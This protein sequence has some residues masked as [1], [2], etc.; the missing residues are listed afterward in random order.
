MH[1]IFFY[2]NKKTRH[3]RGTGKKTTFLKLNNKNNFFLSEIK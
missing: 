1:D 3:V 2:Q